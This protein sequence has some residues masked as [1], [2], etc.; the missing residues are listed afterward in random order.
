MDL[1]VRERERET[2]REGGRE[3]QRERE[4]ELVQQIMASSFAVV[5]HKYSV[6]LH[7]LLGLHPFPS[8]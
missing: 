5:V 3:R 6:V 1:L 7:H 8:S 4:R 2:E